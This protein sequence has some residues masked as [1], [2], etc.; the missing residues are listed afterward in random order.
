MNTISR[1]EP[2]R[3]APSALLAMVCTGSLLTMACASVPPPTDE[4][5]VSTAAVAHAA[6]AGAPLLAPQEMSS[7][8]EKLE[9]A[10][11]AMTAKDYTGARLFA[12]QALVD[13]QLAESR[14]ESAKAR[15]AADEV[16]EASR[17]LRE[18]MNRKASQ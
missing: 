10:N 14:A 11:A 15:K 18:E 1:P 17:A 8:R 12:Q 13:A 3:R 16:Q 2:N 7:A 6:G 4:V 9:R 5:A